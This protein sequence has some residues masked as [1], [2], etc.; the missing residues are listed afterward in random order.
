[1]RTSRLGDPASWRA[2][3]GRDWNAATSS[4][5]TCEPVE[6]MLHDGLTWNTHYGKYVLVGINQTAPAAYEIA[7]K[8]STDLIHWSAPTKLHD[9]K[10]WGSSGTLRMYPALLDP[11]SKARNYDTTG[12]HPYLYFTR[13][14]GDTWSTM[15]RDLVRVPIRLP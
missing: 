14:N 10:G 4:G 6:S 8:T 13:F 15:D 5:D 1:M 9:T 11:S 12:R 7:F 2:W 3:D